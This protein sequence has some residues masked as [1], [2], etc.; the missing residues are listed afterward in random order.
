LANSAQILFEKKED[1]EETRVGKGR[2]K[3]GVAVYWRRC[4][5]RLFGANEERLRTAGSLLLYLASGRN[6]GETCVTMNLDVFTLNR[7]LH[8]DPGGTSER[9][10][11]IHGRA[12]DH[13]TAYNGGARERVGEGGGF[14]SSTEWTEKQRSSREFDVR[15]RT[16]KTGFA[17]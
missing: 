3:S 17:R 13:R 10:I 12:P 1:E 7:S 6:E 16:G 15:Q 4:A 8:T 5:G 9:E 11:N 14:R 2:R